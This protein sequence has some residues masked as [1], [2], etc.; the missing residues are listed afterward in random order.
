MNPIK[1]NGTNRPGY[2]KENVG[3]VRGYYNNLRFKENNILPMLLKN[4]PEN[5]VQENL[6]ENKS[7]NGIL[8]SASNNYRRKTNTRKSPSVRTTRS[9]GSK[10]FYSARSSLR[11][12]KELTKDG[13]NKLSKSE[14][15]TDTINK[16][17]LDKDWENKI[18]WEYLSKN[19]HAGELLK[20]NIERINWD[21]FIYNKNVKQILDTYPDI[22]QPFVTAGDKLAKY[23]YSVFN[24]HVNGTKAAYIEYRRYP[25]TQIQKHNKSL[26]TNWLNKSKNPN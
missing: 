15:V 14:N 22:V 19:S 21:T 3:N 4:S 10:S 18:N 23:K 6:P 17:Y 20:D 26:F 13:W 24:G 5:K 7:K 8:L 2:L 12:G 9:S 1:I 16:Y 25:N 11:E